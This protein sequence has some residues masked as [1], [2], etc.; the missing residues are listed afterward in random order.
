MRNV[1]MGR[2]LALSLAGALGACGDN[3]TTSADDDHSRD[4]P[5][6]RSRASALEKGAEKAAR[7]VA[8]DATVLVEGLK[9][10]VREG[11]SDGERR[12]R[13]VARDEADRAPDADQAREPDVRPRRAPDDQP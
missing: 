13:A 7:G 9:R 6:A 11:V 4:S 1:T 2:A 10:G 12:S 3:G 8:A 5:Q